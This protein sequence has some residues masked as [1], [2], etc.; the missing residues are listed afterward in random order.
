MHV[1]T[2]V[3]TAL[4][5]A[6]PARAGDDEHALW[7]ALADAA[8]ADAVSL[9]LRESRRPDAPSTDELIA[10]L[11]ELGEPAV[12]P[13]VSILLQRSVPPVAAEDKPQVLSEPQRELLLAALESW[14]PEPALA[15]IEDELL[16]GVDFART[17]AAIHVWS[18]VGAPDQW[19]RGAALATGSLDSKR[20]ADVLEKA[21]EQAAQRMLRRRPECFR[22]FTDAYARIDPRLRLR[23]ILGAGATGD[24]RSSELFAHVLVTDPEHAPAA[25]AQVQRIGRSF[26]ARTHDA[27]C[28]ALREKLAH[29]STTARNAAVRALGAQR[30][31]RSI[32]ALLEL[33]EDPDATVRTSAEWS[34]KK[35]TG[36]K[37]RETSAWRAWHASEVRW[38]N[39]RMD[40][41]IDQLTSSSPK[42]VVAALGESALHPLYSSESAPWAVDA[43]QSISVVVRTTAAEA[44]GRL[45]S[46]IAYPALI[47]ALQDADPGVS[48][49]AH[50]SLVRM[51][52]LTLP[53]EVDAWRAALLD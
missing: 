43:L 33:L 46:P 12:S 4:I 9:V 8:P 25:L 23:L 16:L 38:R 30:D 47:E 3:L 44:L 48:A 31:W 24:A 20:R 14:P 34:L 36:L 53:A 10:R 5:G 35:A 17:W 49:A 50:A 27:L 11:A 15:C 2:L 7:R 40:L 13:L 19:E 51:S 41:I 6:S 18:A 42:Q 26:D 45:D 1:L 37:W 39:E 52:G 28:D 21:L 22:T 32:E 29:P